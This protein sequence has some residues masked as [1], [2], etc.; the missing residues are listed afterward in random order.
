MYYNFEAFEEKKNFSRKKSFAVEELNVF[1]G[2][3]FRDCYQIKYLAFQKF[4]EFAK[5]S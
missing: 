1:A 2:I 3:N 4:C 5:K